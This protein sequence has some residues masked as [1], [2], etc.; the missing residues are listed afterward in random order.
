M[1]TS[2]SPLSKVSEVI[3]DYGGWGNF[4]K[5]KYLWAALLLLVPTSS[6]WTRPQWWDVVLDVTPSMLGFTIGGFA[7]I[8]AFGDEKFR[9]LVAR[10]GQESGASVLEELIATFLIFISVQALGLIAAITSKG[11]WASDVILWNPPAWVGM[12]VWGGSYFLFL[13]GITLAVAAARWIHML[14]KTYSIYIKS[15]PPGDL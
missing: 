4:V 9:A 3:H 13:Y 11:L 12:L 2:T 7:L 1:D 8:L 10:A 15:R 5:S 14:G 6:L